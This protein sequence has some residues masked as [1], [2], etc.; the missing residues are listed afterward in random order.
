MTS[1]AARDLDVLIVGAGLSGIGAAWQLQQY[2]AGQRYAIVEARARLGGTW[3]LFRYPGVRSDSDMFTLGYG[4]RPWPEARAIADGP[5]ILRYIQD[6]ARDGGIDRHIHYDQRVVAASWSTPA[7][8]WQVR[9]LDS[10]GSETLWTCRFLY[11]CA[12]YYDTDNGYTPALRGK[13]HF[14]GRIVH[15]QRWPQDLD[16]RG[17]QIVVIGSGAT[18]VTLV[19]ALA[20]LGAKVTM[21]QRTP[22]YVLPV[23]SRDRWASRL[24]RWL[25]ARW[26]HTAAKWKNVLIFMAFYSWC[27]RFPQQARRF[28][29]G[30]ARSRLGD[31]VA[32]APHFTPPYD[33]WQQRLCFAPGGDLYRVLRD[34]QARVVTAAIDTLTVGGVRL[35]TGE[36]LAADVVV[37]AT[38]LQLRLL[39]GM[40][41]EVD[42]VAVDAPSR[43]I[44]KGMMCSG[45]PNFAFTIGYT[46][47]S[48]TLK[49]DLVARYVCRLLRHMERQGLRQCVPQPRAGE[50]G[51]EP[52]ID[53]SSGYV[54]RARDQLP[55]QG[56]RAPWK[57]YQNYLVD[58]LM[59]RWGRLEDGVMHFLP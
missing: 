27:R 24:Q 55:K 51:T 5:A 1:T 50:T 57:L 11:V 40:A 36:E 48:W 43:L 41:L 56:A 33:P 14:T 32:V 4:F 29:Q 16:C 7:A 6:T 15:P 47:A 31:Q 30:T 34:G 28:L 22:S 3:D 10:Q 17:Q 35:H 8:R 53:F 38:G 9:C 19:P 18:A 46:N 58:W 59:L 21:V 25:P 20:G 23:P 52:L 54:L 12:G 2:C 49:A 44:Y 45:V 39:G 42:G 37:T 26:A 13:D